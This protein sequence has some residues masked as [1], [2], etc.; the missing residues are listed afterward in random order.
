VNYILAKN[1]YLL[2]V[3]CIKRKKC[4]VLL[5]T[6]GTDKIVQLLS[7]NQASVDH[8]GVRESTR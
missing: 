3:P 6:D 5:I 2:V 1:K 8:R 7:S 4:A